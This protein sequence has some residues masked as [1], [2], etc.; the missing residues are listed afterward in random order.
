M[1][2]SRWRGFVLAWAVAMLG[3]HAW[4]ALRAA[5]RIAPTFDEPL[6]L[7]AGYTYDR[8]GDF[9]LHPENGVLPQRWA[10]WPLLRMDV[11]LPRVGYDAAWR[12]SD[13]AALSAAFLYDI[14]NDHQA[15]LAAARR[16]AVW[17]SA[18]LGALV[19]AWAWSLWGPTGAA[20]AVTLFALSP[21]TLAHGPLVTSDMSAALL[22][23]LACWA[24]WR[25]LRA[26]SLGSLVLSAVVASL[27]AIAK[28][29]AALLPP[30]FLVLAAWMLWQRPVW[31][32]RALGT[33][34]LNGVTPRLAWIALAIVVHVAVAATVIWAAF[35]FRF[36]AASPEMPAMAQY[37]RLWSHAMPE[38]TMG[39]VLDAMRAWQALPEPYLY[40]FGFVLRF[41]EARA[42]FL[43]GEHG[44][45]GWWWFFPYAFVV[46]S[47]LA[48][49]LAL[50][51]VVGIGIAAWRRAGSDARTRL[52]AMPA[53]VV[54]LLA[55]V[56]VYAA[57]SVTSNLNI[58]HRHLLPV[59]PVLFILAGGLVA[60][61]AA[62]WRQ[63]LAIAVL[64]LAAVEAARIHPHPLAYFNALVG[65]P[66]QGWR[67]L[68]D[69]SLDWGQ[70][71]PALG[72][73]LARE[74]RPG[75][76]VY[77]NIFGQRRAAAY[78]ITG[79]EIAPAYAEVPRRWVEWG[80]G[81]YAVSAT[82]LQDVYSP[83]AGRWDAQKESNFQVLSRNARAERERNPESA[84]IGTQPDVGNN[85]WTLERL[86]FARLVNYLRLRRP[87]AVLGYTVFVHRLSADEART[88]VS[89]D[90]PAYV[91][92]LESAS[93]G[94]E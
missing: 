90:T 4:L 68:V 38:G 23:T 40:G 79:T 10:A 53:G 89:G 54:P 33:R 42:A 35:D 36:A 91:A 57:F 50:G 1:G 74:R 13:I 14:G 6:H 82:M 64:T 84:L 56:G 3:L 66:T 29:S 20:V 83:F 67:Q 9:R 93:A 75:E 88:I 24:W 18:A 71:A 34:T 19:L 5:D 69:S 85:Y 32:L 55:F 16:Q 77:Y 76:A 70:D 80:D 78:G 15:M 65:G 25:H 60:H 8:A 59:Y 49:L 26:P 28:F 62:R 11:E 63:G 45:S 2:E 61:G 37:Y 94:D 17:W 87:D 51:G 7:V 21:T 30:L 47:T 12:T 46:K 27:A 48:E 73:W 44:I 86:Q 31:T 58:G 41:A 39:R 81:I 72:E 22:L 92:L 52:R 43:N